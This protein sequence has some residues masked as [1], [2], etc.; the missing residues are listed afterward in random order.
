MYGAAGVQIG[1]HNTQVLPGIVPRS[2]YAEQVRRIA[3]A[4]LRDRAGELAELAAFCAA[5]EGSPAYL[6]WRAEAWAGTA[7]NDASRAAS[8]TA[9]TKVR[10]RVATGTRGSL[11]DARWAPFA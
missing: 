8:R 1:D 5:P 3:P 7:I 10:E 11:R 2:A 4:E 6:C 9:P